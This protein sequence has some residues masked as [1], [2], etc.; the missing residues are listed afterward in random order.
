[1]MLI[2][3]TGATLSMRLPLGNYAAAGEAAAEGSRVLLEE[4]TVLSRMLQREL[5][6][7]P[8]GGETG[9]SNVAVALT[10]VR[11]TTTRGRV[12]TRKG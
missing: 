12:A 6:A 10:V 7:P 3:R 2:D 5:L 9:T 8:L 1:M 11:R 4:S